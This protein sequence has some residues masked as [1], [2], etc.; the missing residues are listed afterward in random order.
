MKALGILDEQQGEFQEDDPYRDDADDAKDGRI[1]KDR[2]KGEERRKEWLKTPGNPE[3]LADHNAR[4]AAH[5]SSFEDYKAKLTA[6]LKGGRKGPPPIAPPGP[7]PPTGTPIAPRTP[8]CNTFLETYGAKLT[9]KRHGSGLGG[10][11]PA[12]EGLKRNSWRTLETHPEG[13][14][15]GD[16]YS[17]SDANNHKELKHVGTVR[18][19]RPAGSG[20]EVW[21]VVD[22][23]QGTYE[24]RQQV[25]EKTRY[26]DPTTGILSSKLAGAGQTADDRWLRGWID[27]EQHLAT[28]DPAAPR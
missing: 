22:G 17:V 21:T 12:A 7:K 4:M 14:K 6:Y 18:S 5:R 27:I 26:F 15:P 23:G 3:L 20:K 25:L 2:R 16:A 8:V 1:L 24:S 10:F 13:P 9:G 28:P 11:D 19:R